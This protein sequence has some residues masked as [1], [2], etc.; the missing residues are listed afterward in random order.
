ME[1]ISLIKKIEYKEKNQIFPVTFNIGEYL[2]RKDLKN[3][4][5]LIIDKDLLAY[6]GISISEDS[7]TIPV[8]LDTIPKITSTLLENKIDFYGV[9]VLYDKYLEMKEGDKNE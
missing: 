1:K 4:F 2:D 8:T 5:N 6:N 7:F 3:I 9:Y